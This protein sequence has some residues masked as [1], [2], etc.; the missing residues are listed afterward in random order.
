M[1]NLIMGTLVAWV[2]VRYDFPLKRL[3]D[4]QRRAH[5]TGRALQA[6]R[7]R[8]L[9]RGSRGGAVTMARCNSQPRSTAGR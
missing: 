8:L 4:D 6:V 1:L 7:G 2:L 9:G 3:L 5:G